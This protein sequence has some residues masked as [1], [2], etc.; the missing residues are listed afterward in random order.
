MATLHLALWATALSRKDLSNAVV[1]AAVCSFY[2]WAGCAIGGSNEL[3]T[4]IAYDSLSPFCGAE[5]SCLLGYQ[6]RLRTDAQLAALINGI[7]SHAHDY[8]DTHPR[9]L[10]HPS[11][12]VCSALLAYS[13]WKR[14]VSGP[15]FLVAL[16]AGIEAECKVGL[17]V[18]PAHYDKGW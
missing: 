16:V 4:R 14:P 11:A 7:A 2:N 3:A 12:P 5:T 9:S 18:T 1:H 6:G 15:D 8:D 10:I 13:G 17:A